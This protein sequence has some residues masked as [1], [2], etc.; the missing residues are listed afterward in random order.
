MRGGEDC[1]R[2]RM[3]GAEALANILLIMR[4]NAPATN[5]DFDRQKRRRIGSIVAGVAV[6]TGLLLLA[7]T[8]LGQSRP[9]P[10]ASKFAANKQFGV[11]FML[12]DPTGFSGKYYLSADTALDFG[13]G[14]IRLAGPDGVH[15]HMDFLWHPANLATTPPFLLPIYFGLGGRVFSFDGGNDDDNDDFAVGLRVPGGI[16][17]D[18][19]HVPIDV[20]F[21][22]AF[23][24]DFVTEGDLRARFNGAIG[25]R[26]YFN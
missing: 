3:R 13:F 7:S 11:G 19:N 5:A 24:L 26:Y 4:D 17:M 21:E 6:M 25:A 15:A 22:L 23:V 20:F 9:R 12:G 14:L 2:V 16:M 1:T 10:R 18:F 8:A